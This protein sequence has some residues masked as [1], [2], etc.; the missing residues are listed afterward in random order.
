MTPLSRPALAGVLAGLLLAG[1]SAD[2]PGPVP[3]EGAPNVLLVSVDTLRADRVGAY[4]ASFG[5]TPTFDALAAAGLRAEKALS[6]VPITLPAHATLL[7]GLYPPRHGV[8]HNG[9]FRLA[10]EQVTLAERFRDAGYATGAV[11][12]AMVLEA[13]F[14]LAQGFDRYDDHFGSDRANATGYLERPAREVTA[15]AL[16]WLDEVERPFFLFV[17][18][19]DP[20]ADYAP[21]PEFA[22]RFPGRP[23]EGEIAS[24]DAAVGELLAGL[25]A[26]G[27]LEGTVVAVTADHGESLGEHG[28][29]THS[30]TLYDATLA[31]PLILQGP[32]VPSG[33]TLPGVVSTA[34]VAP[35]LLRLAG[36]A[37][38][39]ESDGEDLVARAEAPPASGGD[40]YAETLATQLDH[41]WAPLYAL[42]TPQ[43]HFVRAPRPELYAVREDP[44]ELRNLLPGS[45]PPEAAALDAA[46]SARLAGSAPLRTAPVDAETKQQLRAL[47]YALSDA[48]VAETGLDPKDGLPL[49]EVYVDARNAFYAG[50]LEKA[51]RRAREMLAASPGSGQAHA[52]LSGIAR[53]RGDLRGALAEA[54]RAAERL[55]H[56]A[57]F[58]SEIGD[59]RLELG[60]LPGALAAY[61]A[62]LAIDPEFAE[63]RAG[64]MWR[65][66]V[67]KD[68]S[69]A[70]AEAERALAIRPGDPLLRLRVAQN[71]DRLGDAERALDG[72]RAT[73]RLD[74]RSEAA[75]MG[76]AIQ[77]AR[78]GEDAEADEHLAAA[79]SYAREPNHRN[80]LAIAYAARGEN[81]RAEALF[82]DVLAAHPDHPNARRNLA[83]LLRTTGRAGEAAELERGDGAG[84][85]AN[86][87]G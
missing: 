1:C 75:H 35:T 46:I 5:A 72:F 18:Y 56:S 19:Y 9:I 58:H 64:T 69:L 71:F 44:H 3:R 57:A 84:S 26:R 15:A 74:P 6:P 73:L 59:L 62:A 55:P 70:A 77:L 78:L 65:A 42:R 2:A 81:S 68:A 38:F 60:D 30:Y 82:R 24:V 50:D 11:V 13:R 23:Y 37:P 53:R 16:R 87:Q 85:S 45:A 80:R 66:A 54:E 36:L 7:T 21:P 4:G 20:H 61:D 22:A 39:A 29:R 86:S 33:R 40:A 48:P 83:H 67:A 76:A 41:G 31:V 27:R 63:A 34:S 51:E 12:G 52:L 47:G 14:G 32:G 43:H 28:E 8:R 10:A 17:H 49:V 79:G 25:R